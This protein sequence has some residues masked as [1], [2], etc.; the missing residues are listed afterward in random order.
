MRSISFSLTEP[1]FLDGSKDVTRR[2]GWLKLKAGDRLRAC[3]K[4][5]G[6]KKGEKQHVL[7]IIE[8]VSVRRE[9]L[10]NLVMS[11]VY[12]VNDV[13]REGFQPMTGQQFIEFFCKSHRGCTP[14][15]IVTRIEFK[16]LNTAYE[17]TR[18][19]TTDSK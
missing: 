15:T 18:Q 17:P 7:G 1:Q 16:R 13:R 2:L 14:H 3:R 11:A 12:E 6:L 19:K 8:V 4:C 5:M 9:P 10:F